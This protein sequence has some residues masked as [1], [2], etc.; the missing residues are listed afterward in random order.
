MVEFK[1]RQFMVVADPSQRTPL[2]PNDLQEL[3]K[4]MQENH[5]DKF[6]SDPQA[7]AAAHRRAR[8]PTAQGH[9]GGQED[10]GP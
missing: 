7:E 3:R 2:R 1:D 8:L 9:E 5:P 6:A 4:K 10:D